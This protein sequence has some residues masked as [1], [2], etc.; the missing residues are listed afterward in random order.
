MTFNLVWSNY[1][2]AISQYLLLS[3]RQYSSRVASSGNYCF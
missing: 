1:K 3:R 2:I